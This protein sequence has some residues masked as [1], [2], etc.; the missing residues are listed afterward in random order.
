MAFAAIGGT[1]LGGTVLGG[2]VLGGTVLGGTLVPLIT[3]IQVMCL[4][5]QTSM[6]SLHEPSA[7]VMAI[8]PQSTIW[9][10][11]GGLP[12]FS[13]FLRIRSH[14]TAATA[15]DDRPARVINAS[16][17]AANMLR[18]ESFILSVFPIFR[19]VLFSKLPISC[20]DHR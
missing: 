3:F 10:T 18:G 2:T 13:A 9:V 4:A 16:R 12:V 19:T 6:G 7:E 5:R 20:F 15:G 17:T 11:V 8:M 14:E 1:V